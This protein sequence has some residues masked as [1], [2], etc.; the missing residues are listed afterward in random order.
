M[1]CE[2][3]VVLQELSLSLLLALLV[4]PAPLLLASVESLVVAFY[5]VHDICWASPV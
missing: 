1:V 2:S 3:G 5:V 4:P